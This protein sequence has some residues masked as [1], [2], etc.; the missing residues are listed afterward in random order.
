MTIKPE[1]LRETMRQWTTGVC[2]VCSCYGNNVHGMTV[3]SFTSISLDP[4]MV[5]VTIANGTRTAAILRESGKFSV[6]I[7]G[8]GQKI[9]AD[10]FSG[11][12]G[13][14]E[15]RF[16]GVSTSKLPGGQLAINGS[17]AVLECHVVDSI[18]YKNST[19]YLAEVEYSTVQESGKP[20]VY[21]NR[22]YGTY[23]H[24]NN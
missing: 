21:H 5:S 2:V 17:L 23:E 11:K 1:N 12:M 13:E 9:I 3:N 14:D 4:P 20:L 10:R 24:S 18:T 19:I 15:N 16:E 22:E 7:L 6:S 8:V